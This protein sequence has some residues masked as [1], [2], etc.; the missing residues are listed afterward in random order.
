[1]VGL[2]CDDPSIIAVCEDAFERAASLQE[3]KMLPRSG[4]S[5]AAAIIKKRSRRLTANSAVFSATIITGS[6]AT[7][8]HVL[9]QV[10]TSLD[11][12]GENLI[13]QMA[14]S[15]PA[16]VQGTLQ[17][18]ETAVSREDTGKPT[19]PGCHVRHAVRV[20]PHCPALGWVSDDWGMKKMNSFKDRESCLK[21]KTAHDYWYFVMKCGLSPTSEHA[22]S[23]EWYFIDEPL[24]TAPGCYVRQRQQN[25]RCEPTPFWVKDTWG[26]KHAD[27]F[28]SSTECL[29]RKAKHDTFCAGGLSVDAT[30]ATSEWFFVP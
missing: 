17:I 16:A 19:A 25:F 24:P 3:R 12:T 30:T 5:S 23:S 29:A 11:T 6:A 4:A 1:M 26:Q 13:S 8:E 10:S 15:F 18:T 28:N 21:R 22:E 9:Q 7:A 14:S 2:S 20:A 27:S